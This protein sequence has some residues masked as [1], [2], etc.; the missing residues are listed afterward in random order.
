MPVALLQL[1]RVL[2]LLAL[3]VADEL[4]LGQVAVAARV[5]VGPGLILL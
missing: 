1:D 5:T 3:V 4:V 2:V